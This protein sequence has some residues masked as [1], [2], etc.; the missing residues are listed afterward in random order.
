MNEK[1]SIRYELV[2]K[3]TDEFLQ[4]Q[5]EQSSKVKHQVEHLLSEA[6]RSLQRFVKDSDEYT[7]QCNDRQSHYGV[8]Y[9]KNMKHLQDIFEQLIETYTEDHKNIQLSINENIENIH[10]F[11]QQSLGHL[12]QQEDSMQLFLNS[13]VQHFHDIIHCLLAENEKQKQRLAETE[14]LIERNAQKQS[15]FLDEAKDE[16]LKAIQDTLDKL[17]TKSKSAQAETAKENKESLLNCSNG[18]TTMQQQMQRDVSQAETNLEEY[19]QNAIRSKAKMAE[20]TNQ[21]LKQQVDRENTSLQKTQIATK[22]LEQGMKEAERTRMDGI[23]LHKTYVQDSQSLTVEYVKRRDTTTERATQDMLNSKKLTDEHIEQSIENDTRTAANVKDGL[24]EEQLALQDFKKKQVGY[25]DSIAS[26]VDDLMTS[27][28]RVDEPTCTTPRKRQWNYPQVLETT[29]SY[30]ELLRKFYAS[31]K[32][33][34]IISDESDDDQQVL[35]EANGISETELPNS[36]EDISLASSRGK[37]I[38]QEKTSDSL[39]DNSNK[40]NSYAA[41]LR[42]RGSLLRLPKVYTRRNH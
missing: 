9:N 28:L 11:A 2:E 6:N 19:R 23:E 32:E 14:Q 41:D 24:S 18:L 29:P 38:F 31:Y 1:F 21:S 5:R 39:S 10:T 30:E 35:R 27:G 7:K 15:E 40:E 25:V 33:P 8:E 17:V 26:S 20:E 34:S 36:N 22:H 37:L 12:Q 4:T 42:Q 16:A 13:Q 3:R